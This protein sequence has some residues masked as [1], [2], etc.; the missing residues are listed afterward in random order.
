MNKPEWMTSKIEVDILRA[1]REVGK[2]VIQ[3]YTVMN[4]YR[5]LPALLKS[6][7]EDFHDILVAV[8]LVDDP[9]MRSDTIIM[10]VYQYFQEVR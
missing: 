2:R 5:E 1:H 10:L 4:H 7:I 3:S 8:T 9:A 6:K